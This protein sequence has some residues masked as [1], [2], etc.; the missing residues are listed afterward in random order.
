MT[1][2]YVDS[3]CILTECVWIHLYLFRIVDDDLRTFS[4]G[5]SVILARLLG[6]I[7]GPIFLGRIIDNACKLWSK[8]DCESAG[9]CQLYNLTLFS[10][11]V[12]IFWMVLSGLACV[13]FFVASIFAKRASKLRNESAYVVDETDDGK[14]RGAAYGAMF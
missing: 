8:Q 11:S 1:N 12:M 9:V 13:S 7:P 3:I 14:K 4:M 10:K 5:V 2:T 6:Q